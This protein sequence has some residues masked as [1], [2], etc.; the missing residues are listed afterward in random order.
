MLDPTLFAG[1]PT[2][3]PNLGNVK[4]ICACGTSIRYTANSTEYMVKGRQKGMDVAV[5][6]RA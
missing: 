3:S 4:R 1:A 2:I 6:N 5:S